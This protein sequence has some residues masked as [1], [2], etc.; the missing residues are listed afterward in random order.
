MSYR[1]PLPQYYSD[2]PTWWKNLVKA[3]CNE[4]DTVVNDAGGQIQWAG[5]LKGR[6]LSI[7]FDTDAHYTWF[8][9]RWS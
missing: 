5:S 7:E 4:L 8:V 3:H 1:V 6:A 9:L 2:C